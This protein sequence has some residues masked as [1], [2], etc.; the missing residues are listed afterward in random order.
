MGAVSPTASFAMPDPIIPRPRQLRRRGGSFVPTGRL[1]IDAPAE[2]REAVTR[3]VAGLAGWGIE[4]DLVAGS[5]GPKRPDLIF[6]PMADGAENA[7]DEAYRLIVSPAGGRLE[8]RT[9]S[10]W[11]HAVQTLLDLYDPVVGDWPLMEVKDEPRFAWRGLM[12]DCCRHFVSK[13]KILQ[14][15]DEMA[16]CKLNRFHWHLTDDQAWRIEIKGYPRL[17]DVGARRADENGGN[18]QFYTQDDVREIVQHAAGLGIEVMPEIEMPGHASAVLAAYPELGCHREPLQPRAEWGLFPHNFNAGDDKVFTFLEGVLAEVVALFPFQ[19]IHLGADECNKGQWEKCPDCQRRIAEE[20]LA[21]E[22]ALQSYFLNRIADYLNR[23]GRRAMGWDE[24]LEGFPRADMLVHAWRDER[25]I[26]IA[27][28]RG[29][30]VIASPRRFCYFD[31]AVS[32]V[33]L[34]D[35]YRFDPCEGIEGEAENLVLGGEANMWTEYVKEA[36]LEHMLFPRLWALSEALWCGGEGKTEFAEFKARVDLISA[37]ARNRGLK[38]GPA[39]RGEIPTASMMGRTDL[40]EST[41][42][43]ENLS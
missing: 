29:F 3:L 22:D 35:V 2:A 11:G 21:D 5:G 15:L 9:V 16:A 4:A 23:H 39:L 18:P 10:G 36:D 19:F 6:A 30:G 34:S 12:L 43:I 7:S 17:T 24:I 25:I 27:T 41:P 33:D 40:K 14:L 37:R 8:A 28:R 13:S 26:K 31:L 42:N 1:L 20:G 38:P 32:Q